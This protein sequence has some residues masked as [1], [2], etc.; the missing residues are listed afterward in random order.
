MDLIKHAKSDPV[1][2]AGLASVAAAAGF[3][4]YKK[5]AIPGSVIE[6]ERNGGELVANVLRAHG[7]AS[8][9]ERGSCECNLPICLFCCRFQRSILIVRVVSTGV[10][11]VFTLV[12]K[13][14]PPRSSAKFADRIRLCPVLL[15]PQ[16]GIFRLYS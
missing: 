9:Y 5:V 1:V 11:F 4:L 13:R 14:V 6:T 10:P 15:W 16:V 7:T 12:G 3:I 8:V 2:A